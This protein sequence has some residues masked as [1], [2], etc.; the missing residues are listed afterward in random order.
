MMRS[1][2]VLPLLLALTGARAA[3]ASDATLGRA[4]P[5][6]LTLSLAEA[7]QR[8]R[9]DSPTATE[10]AARVAQAK[11]TVHLATQP[12]QPLLAAQGGY[13]RNNAEAKVSF[14][15]IFDT[16]GSAL[17]VQIDIDTSQLPADLIIQPLDLW[18]GGA[19]LTVP[20]FDGVAWSNLGAAKQ[21]A[22]ATA[23]GVTR[24]REQAESGL[25]K[26][27]W[28]AQA[29]E[30][31]LDA[32][33]RA[34]QAAS[35]HLDDAQARVDAGLG[36]RLEVLQAQ[37]ELSRRQSEVVQAAADV[38]RAHRFVAALL[39][40]DGPVRIVPPELPLG[41]ASSSQ[42][43]P[44]PDDRADVAAKRFALA[45]SQAQVRSAWWRHAPTF[46]AFGQVSAQTTPFP[47]GLDYAWR[48]GVQATWVLY[49]GGARY[50]LLEQA[51]AQRLSAEAGLE[52][53]RRD[54]AREAADAAQGIEVAAERVRLAE[55]AVATATDGAGTA[56]RL[57]AAGVATSLDVVDANQRLRD[58]E[59]A[60]ARARAGAG[61]AWVDLGLATGRT[62]PTP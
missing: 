48:V 57:Y 32:A 5:P 34:V 7:T 52:Q 40:V 20:L 44:S 60:L 46:Q 1:L 23:S 6:V 14:A 45:A 21:G 16:L 50:G 51:R 25:A 36:T 37:T 28:Q 49:D 62:D 35:A 26:A 24:A 54:A 29:A 9:D 10:L 33:T 4:E 58:T 56:Q 3:L 53:A 19:S 59:V 22:R 18:S 41:G 43:D 17:P 13:T 11:A 55:A 2:R 61:I 31:V 47:T 39:G 42:G 38:D 8:F 30:E 12:L 15:T 27:A